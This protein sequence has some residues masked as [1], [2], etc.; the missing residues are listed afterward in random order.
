[1][2]IDQ[3]VLNPASHNLLYSNQLILL[4]KHVKKESKIEPELIKSLGGNDKKITFLINNKLHPFLSEEE[5]STLEKILSACKLNL[6]DIAII[7][8][9][10]NQSLTYQEIASVFHPQKWIIFGLNTSQLDL[11][12]DVPHFQVQKFQNSEYVFAPNFSTLILDAE[13]KKKLWQSLQKMF[14]V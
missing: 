1:M 5:M 6:A 9:E 2:S 8:F 14:L 3:I 13:L 11:P 7:N 4:E 12:F 10:K